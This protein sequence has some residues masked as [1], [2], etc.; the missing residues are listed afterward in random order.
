ML[1]AIPLLMQQRG[2]DAGANLGVACPPSPGAA[3]PH[4]P[5]ASMWKSRHDTYG[6]PPDCPAEEHRPTRQN[7]HDR[8]A[9]PRTTE[10]LRRSLRFRL[11]LPMNHPATP[12]F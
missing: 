1:E 7:P 9:A 6:R 3:R 12:V 5:E 10:D 2:I 8:A 4:N 11:I